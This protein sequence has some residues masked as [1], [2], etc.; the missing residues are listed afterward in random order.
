MHGLREKDQLSRGRGELNP[1]S[2]STLERLLPANEHPIDRV[3]RVAIGVAILSLLFIGPRSPWAL[4]GLLPLITGLVG[5]CPLYTLFGVSTCAPHRR[6]PA[7]PSHH[8]A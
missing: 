7:G 8:G 2:M 5:S 4:V 6:R 3:L 1:R